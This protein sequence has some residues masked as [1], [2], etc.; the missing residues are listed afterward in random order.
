MI[1][2][3]LPVYLLNYSDKLFKRG[4]NIR[5]ELMGANSLNQGAVHSVSALM[6]HA[7]LPITLSSYFHLADWTLA[8]LLSRPDIEPMLP[9]G[10]IAALTGTAEASVAQAKRR[11]EKA[12]KS[13]PLSRIAADTMGHHRSAFYKRHG[14]PPANFDAG[15]PHR[16]SPKIKA[17]SLSFPDWI[18]ILSALKRGLAQESPAEI[19]RVISRPVKEIAGWL[20]CFDTLGQGR[21]SLLAR[22]KTPIVSGTFQTPNK[23]VLTSDIEQAA[24]IWDKVAKLTRREMQKIDRLLE[25]IVRTWSDK[26]SGVLMTN[27]LEAK[28]IVSSLAL[29]GIQ[30]W[31]LNLV[32]YRA[33][34]IT[35]AQA[36]RAAAIWPKELGISNAD[37]TYNRVVQKGR[38]PNGAVL[39]NVGKGLTASYGFRFTVLMLVLA[40]HRTISL[41]SETNTSRSILAEDDNQAS[42]GFIHPASGLRTA[43]EE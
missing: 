24:S 16:R 6:G 30:R 38:R 2:E 20:Q 41:G 27:I 1:P 13:L 21:G 17:G 29:L 43:H 15:E 14:Y 34:K 26:P 4:A 3:G 28:Q 39:L 7:D 5:V 32:V 37:I 35:D 31:R 9:F 12:A 22:M 25:V 8:A 36:V 19:S 10:I 42:T 40:R 33:P 18:D 23:P 11:R